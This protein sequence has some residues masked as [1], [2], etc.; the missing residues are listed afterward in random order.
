MAP[1]TWSRAV[2][3]EGAFGR[4]GRLGISAFFSSF[5]FSSF[6]APASFPSSFF[7]IRIK[8]G[9][10]NEVDFVMPKVTKN[11]SIWVPFW[12]PFWPRFGT[13]SGTGPGR[14][15]A[16]KRGPC[17]VPEGVAG[18]AGGGGVTKGVREVLAIASTL[19][20]AAKV[21]TTF[22]IKGATH[23]AA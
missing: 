16:P 14:P 10:G 22:E 11:D 15:M 17:K 2:R 5:P 4:F 7:T 18:P 1:N 13:R 9:S 19:M 23:E 12:L 3:G 6:A 8:F 20:P 21:A